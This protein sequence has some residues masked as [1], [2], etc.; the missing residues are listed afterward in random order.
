MCIHSHKNVY[1]RAKY[2]HA[3]IYTYM[4]ILDYVKTYQVTDRVLRPSGFRKTILFLL[5]KS[6][7]AMGI[8]LIS[9]VQ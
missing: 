2:L 8:K 6:F 5:D 9:Q 3:C 1:D 7:P 4:D